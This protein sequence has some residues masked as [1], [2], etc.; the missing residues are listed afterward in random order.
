MGSLRKFTYLV[1]AIGITLCF[2]PSQDRAAA[3]TFN[4]SGFA[5]ERI[6]TLSPF[7]LVGM[8]FAPD[9]RLFVWQKN[10]VV[11]VIKNGQLLPTP[12]IDLSAKVNTF[13]DRGFWGL[14]FDPQFAS[15]GRIYM[16]YT[17]ENAGNPNSSAPRTARLVRVTADPANPDVALPGSEQV[18][19]GSIGTP[20]CSAQPAS[21]DCIGSDGGS[22]TLGSLHFEDD[23]T[24]FVGVGDGS[25]GDANSLRAQNLDSPN[26]KILRIN[27]DGSAPADNP[28]YDGTNS[29]RSRVW[30]YGMRNPFG[31]AIQP[32]TDEMY[33]GDVGWNT[34][35]E[36]NHGRAGTNF[37]WPCYEGNGP[38]PFFQTNFAGECALISPVTP[39]LYTY[40]HSFGSAVIGGPFYS[41]A[42]YPA[43]YHDSFFF[44]DYSGNWIQRVVFD[45][46]HNPVS[47]QPFATDVQSPVNL[48]LGPD[49]MLYYLSFTTGEIRRIRFNGPVAAASAT[50]PTYGYS[51]LSVSFSSAGS[52]NPGGGQ[53]SY[54]WDFGDGTTSTAANP[55]HTYTS[56]TV[57]TFTA[58]LTVTSQS[59]TSSTDTVSVTVGSL[60]PAPS[61]TA[62]ANNTT[63]Y[64]GQTVTYRGSA[65]DPDEGT[66]GGSALSW[67]VL[68]HHNTH[69]HT[70]VGGAGDQGSFTAEDHGDI[71]TFSYEIVLTAT[72]SSGLKSTTSVNLPVGADSSP[73]TDPTGLNATASGS[74]QVGLSWTA[75]T[76]NV[77]VAGYRVERCQGAGCTNFT[78]VGTP[79][80]T[81]FSDTFLAPSSTYR[82]RVR[83]IDASGNLSGY[84]TV[85]EATTGA[86]PPPPPGLVGA[87]A[88]AE[89]NGTTTADS[90]GNGN[91]GTITGASWTTQ[92]RFGNALSF[93]G[94]NSLV[95]VADSAS[96]DLTTAMTLSAWIEP[97]ASQSGWRTILQHETDAYFLNASNS[98]GPLRPS[99]GGTLGGNT[100]Y[101][102][103]PSANPVNAWTNV[104][105]TYD[106][107]T[108]RL[109]ING[110]QVSSRAATGAIQT[111]NS[112][113]W[114][115]G[116]SPYGE[117]FQGLIDE[118][119]VYNRALTQAE[120]QSD[121]NT[122]IVPTAP[123]TSPPTAPAGLTATASGSSQVN[124]NWTASTDNVGVAGYRVERCQGTGC[125]NFA[126]VGTPTATS[127]SDTGLAPSSTY[128][129]QVR[130]VDASGNFSGY[131]AV[132]SASTPA[133]SDTTPPSAPSGLAATAVSA[134]RIDLNWT[135]ATDNVGVAGYQVERC[136]GTSCTNF[137][138]VGTPTA[139]TY[140]STGLQANTSYR[141][142]A[143]AVDA[144][145]NLSPYSAIVTGRTLANDTTRPSA[146]TGLTAT[147]VGSTAIN[148]GWT[149]S[150]DNVGVAGYQVER[151]Q[152]G[153]CTNFAQIATPA[154]TTYGDAGLSPSTMYRYRVRA[155]DAAGNLST[156]STVATATTAALQD[157]VPPTD[158][159][160]LT[161]TA[162]GSSQVGLNWTA[163]SDN[164][165]VAG[166]RVE[167]CLGASCTNF[168]QIATP[169]A[170]TYGDAGL[171]PSSTY[172]YRVRAV[173]PSGNLSGYSAV[174]AATTGAAPT[175]PPGLVGAWAFAEG[176]GT[177]TADASGKG[178]SGTL[179]G[180]SWTTQGRYGNALSFNG[181]NS[182]VRVADSASLDLT[183]AMTLS[184]WIRPTASQSGWRT[185][186][187]RQVDAYFLNASNSDGP[188]RPSGGGTFGGNTQYLSGP[189][190]NPV[191]AWT[192]VAFTYDG[193]TQ[194]L[195][196]NGTQVASR[197][198]TGAIQTTDNPLWIGGNSPYGEYFQ[199]L[200]DEARVYNRALTQAEI[201]SDMNAPVPSGP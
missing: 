61:I 59:G 87:W 71:G 153:G 191:N 36:V 65:T 154:T 111:T 27:P 166:Y 70:F 37:G 190:A 45:A 167:R 107:A 169:T 144:A 40:D 4:D 6:A 19:L 178:N 80:A 104:A 173:D 116:N 23:G 10:G 175:T 41:G 67:T 91:A 54:L 120:I 185:I 92:G 148:V 74:S 125:T 3:D 112:P 117:Y 17:F 102:S 89:G 126:Q 170:T 5:T 137:A 68:L 181:T 142:R 1:A 174:A 39:P 193:A 130:A 110:T 9:G 189:T 105:L 98:D 131:S 29:W 186:F 143:R 60:P 121:M 28:F 51:P 150:T 128:R 58:R 47:V 149:A 164:V 35:E 161:A 151:C 2:L 122:S 75:S 162:V 183:T 134:S 152:G 96:L 188:L 31:Y 146:P 44:A 141:F 43:Q 52:S 62:P 78:Q 165:G 180:A 136:Q 56:S 30:A 118:A 140:S 103:G 22:H 82:Y 177:T 55:S 179:M 106:G 158:P 88:F 46:N 85:A 159:T 113:L 48:T 13:D 34:W 20:P 197:A 73:P 133:Q 8:A 129:Y 26:G 115:G 95:R 90:S 42:V 160:G 57:R 199:G 38:Q 50:T 139:T 86:A 171:A 155:V 21:A 99:G 25:D 72:D 196:I 16:T 100:Q 182:L 201:Q 77:G 127:Y 32:G 192:D 147:T 124:L 145:G 119:R 114:I 187:Q 200:I 14:A 101:L 156:Y 168:A 184:A 64:P 66:L 138:Q 198:T 172:R 7:T 15:N 76:D 109:Y 18:I 94:T 79:T 157:T 135:A 11:R 108:L 163:S 33:L 84:S 63:V 97:T 24:L 123:D 69:V 176:A 195:Y 53:L 93:N 49:G 83:A 194:R 12:F 81:T 132:A